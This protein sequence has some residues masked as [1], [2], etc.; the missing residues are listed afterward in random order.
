MVVG[1]EGEEKEE[2]LV[3]PGE[4]LGKASL[5]IPGRGAY[6]APHNQTIYASLTGRRHLIPPPSH[7]PNQVPSI[8]SLG[9]GL[10]FLERMVL[11]D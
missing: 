7:S 3:T 2:E 9:L 10:G 4:V 8:L 1:K 11:R 6:V 5:L